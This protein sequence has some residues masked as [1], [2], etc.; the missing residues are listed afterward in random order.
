MSFLPEQSVQSGQSIVFFC[1]PLVPLRIQ[2]ILGKFRK[3]WG[4]EGPPPFSGKNR[5]FGGKTGFFRRGE[6]PFSGNKFRG[7]KQTRRPDF[8]QSD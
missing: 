3:F 1:V 6:A 4:A 7:Q 5:K 2:E 8:T